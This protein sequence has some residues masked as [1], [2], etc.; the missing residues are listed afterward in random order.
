MYSK[1]IANLKITTSFEKSNCRIPLIKIIIKLHCIDQ[2]YLF[3]QLDANVWAFITLSFSFLT[4]K[5]ATY[6]HFFNYPFISYILSKS[7]RSLILLTPAMF[8]L[9]I[10]L[11]LWVNHNL[12]FLDVF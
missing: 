10:I 11:D 2:V 1:F 4:E 3:I 5:Q 8:S 9:Y 7:D 6:L 12:L